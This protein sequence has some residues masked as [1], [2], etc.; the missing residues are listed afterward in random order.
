MRILPCAVLL[1][2]AALIAAQ[3]EKEKWQ[4]VYT[5]EDSIIE[6]ELAKVTFGS[7]SIGRVRFRTTFSKPQTLNEKP[8]VKYKKRLETIEFRC[9][10]D[11]VRLGH[12]PANTT[13]Y[14]LFEATLLDAKGKVVK[15][16]DW[17]PS[18]G[19]REVKFGSMMEKLSVPACKLIEEKRRNP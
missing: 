6:M 3:E 17:D 11:S 2:A 5:G 4:R 15:P 16:L 13:R 18:E 8:V 7:A 19:W 12:Y 1:L 10:M 9:E 14:R